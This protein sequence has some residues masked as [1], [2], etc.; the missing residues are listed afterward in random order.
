M[1][2]SELRDSQGTVLLRATGSERSEAHHEEVETRERN[3]VHGQLAEIAV[4]WPGK[5]K[6]Q[7]VPQIAAETKWFKSP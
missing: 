6:Q 2:L 1:L 4:N 3:H 5:R 7:V